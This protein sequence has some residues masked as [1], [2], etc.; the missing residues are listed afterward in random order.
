[1]FNIT[2]AIFNNNFK[3][4]FINIEIIAIFLLD[5]KTNRK[6]FSPRKT[7]NPKKRELEKE[8]KINKIKIIIK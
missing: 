4:K 5:L 8:K 2:N 1:M 7:I 6:K 3:E